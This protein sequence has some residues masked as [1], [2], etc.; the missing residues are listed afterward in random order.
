MSKT[1][2]IGMIFAENDP[3]CYLKIGRVCWVCCSLLHHIFPKHREFTEEFKQGPYGSSLQ[4]PILM[5]P[6]HWVKSSSALELRSHGLLENHGK[7]TIDFY[8]FH[9]RKTL[10]MGDIPAMVLDWQ[11]I[12]IG[13]VLEHL[14]AFI[15]NPSNNLYIYIILYILLII[16]ITFLVIIDLC[17]YIDM[18]V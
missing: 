12:W 17:I 10:F 2:D 16:I 7:P 13:E 15:P 1:W 6:M 9:Q 8:D 11:V 18:C 4:D 14:A 5:P 3:F